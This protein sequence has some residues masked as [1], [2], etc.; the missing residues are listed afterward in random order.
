MEAEDLILDEGCQGKEV[1]Q[2]SE[3]FPD[4]RIAVF[5]KALIIKTVDLGNLAGL[6][7]AAEDG[8]ARG[9]A[10][11]EGDEEGDGFDTVIAAIDIVALQYV[12]ELT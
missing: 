4:V 5:T 11:F 8:D 12:R 9:I 10:D 7:V 2:I 1:E 3:V 6:V